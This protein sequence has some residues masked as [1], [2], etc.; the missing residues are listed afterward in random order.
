MYVVSF[1][2]V[3]TSSCLVYRC[4]C[5]WEVS[6]KGSCLGGKVILWLMMMI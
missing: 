1:L 2:T 4:Y 5:Q 3:Y 6:W